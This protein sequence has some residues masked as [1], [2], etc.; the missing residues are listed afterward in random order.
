M[1]SEADILRSWRFYRH[2]YRCPWATMASMAAMAISLIWPL[3]QYS[4]SCH[5]CHSWSRLSIWVSN[6]L[7]GPQDFSRWIW[8]CI[9]NKFRGYKCCWGELQG[10]WSRLSIWVSNEASGP[11]DIS[12]WSHFCLKK[13]FDGLKIEN[14]YG[15][16]CSVYILEILCTFCWKRGHLRE[17]FHCT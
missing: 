16:I 5:R 13:L 10:S 4:H 17:H 1:A 9:K 14:A 12:L 7:S 2:L 11:Q 8:F 6:A 15:N 3:W